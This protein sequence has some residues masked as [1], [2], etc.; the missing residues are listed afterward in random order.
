[1]YGFLLVFCNNFVPNTHRFWDIRLVSIPWPWNPG[2]GSLK[3]IENVTIR[4]SAYYILLTFHSNHGPI[5]YR[6]RDIRRFQ[7]KSQNFP[8]PL[9]FAPLLK[10]S[11]LELGTGVGIKKLEWWSYWAD[12][13]VWWYLQSCGCNAPT[14]QTD[15]QTDKRQGDSKDRAYA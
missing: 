3:V 14:W 8:T 2:L 11:P 1:M 13:E 6:F 4:Y 9:Y 15:I 7:S 5:S 10:G 12:K